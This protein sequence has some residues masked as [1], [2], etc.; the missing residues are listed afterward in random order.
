[1]SPEKT[2]QFLGIA[3]FRYGLDENLKGHL[4]FRL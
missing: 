4:N 2:V 1:M 3:I